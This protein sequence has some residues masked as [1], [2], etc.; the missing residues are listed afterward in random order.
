MHL[1]VGYGTDV[2]ILILWCIHLIVRNF[3][4]DLGRERKE[5]KKEVPNK[6]CSVPVPRFTICLV[7]EKP[8]H[9][10]IS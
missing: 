3:D 9:L 7:S 6:I 5:C 2:F 8:E 1:E 10:L 4:I